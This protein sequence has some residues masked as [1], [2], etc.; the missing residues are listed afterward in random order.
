MADGMEIS[1]LSFIS[2]CA[3][4]TFDLSDAQI[5]LITSIVFAGELLG[6]VSYV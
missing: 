5:A 6:T 4:E 1:L 2:V 3:G